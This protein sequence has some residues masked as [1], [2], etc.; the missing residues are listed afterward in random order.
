MVLNSI[1]DAFSALDSEWRYIYLNERV[2]EHSGL[3]RQE[4]LGRSIWEIFPQLVG[5]EFHERCLRALA[6]QAPDHFEH[7]H[8]QWGRW[9]ETRL[10]PA[11][12]GL[13]ILRTDSTERKEQEKRMLESESRLQ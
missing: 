9:F 13:V 12:D 5:G 8:E 10:Y 6:A 1:G 4:M 2:A 11:A 3:S 7:L